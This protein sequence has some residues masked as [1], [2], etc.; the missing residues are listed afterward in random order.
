MCQKAIRLGTVRQE[1][2]SH[3]QACRAF[4]RSPQAK[5]VTSCMIA[6]ILAVYLPPGLDRISAIVSRESGAI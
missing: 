3:W 5:A 4:S 6:S 1:G 2:D